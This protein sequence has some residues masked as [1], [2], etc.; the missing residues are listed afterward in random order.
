MAS[1]AA[2]PA[3]SGF[4]YSGVTGAITFAAATQPTRTFWSTGDAWGTCEQRP[5]SGGITVGLTVLGGSLH[6][7]EIILTGGGKLSLPREATIGKGK[8]REFRV[9]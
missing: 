5:G 2:V 9:G 7:K 6:L 3:L 1:W 8:T 4:Q